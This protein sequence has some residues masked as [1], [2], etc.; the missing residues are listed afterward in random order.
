MNAN[1]LI[2]KWKIWKAD[3]THIG[4]DS[5]IAK[6]MKLNE[7][8][9]KEIAENKP[10][11]LRILTEQ[12]NQ[13]KIERERQY[14]EE[15]KMQEELEI[16]RG[17]KRA[18]VFLE[19]GE[20]WIEKYSVLSVYPA[21]EEEK[22]KSNY[23]DEYKV[24][25]H[26]LSLINSNEKLFFS[27]DIL[28]EDIE[29]CEKIFLNGNRGYIISEE[30]EKKILDRRAKRIEEKDR[31]NTEKIQKEKDEHQAIFQKARETG[32]AQVIS[33]CYLETKEGEIWSTK[34]A[35]PDGTIQYTEQEEN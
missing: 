17:T 27:E 18:V 31:K 25:M 19:N 5:K 23:K 9:K 16:S 28:K 30:I 4:I 26:N 20:G 14:Q 34:L 11:I 15:K 22:K 29:D 3:E 8:D 12:E 2:A 10:E 6:K 7:Q 33:R 24:N 32:E 21:S 35:M 13:I 1:E